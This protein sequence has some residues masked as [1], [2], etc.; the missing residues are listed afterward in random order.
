M[1]H[2]H[3]ERLIEFAALARRPPA[4]SV[5]ASTTVPSP[6]RHGS[7]H[8]DH[9]DDGHELA[10][11]QLALRHV[12]AA[13]S[14]PT[15]APRLEQQLT[16]QSVARAEPYTGDCVCVCACVRGRPS[17]PQA[18]SYGGERVGV[19]VRVWSALSCARGAVHG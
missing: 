2:L 14:E 11:H 12:P 18:E 5:V 13:R 6:D 15:T 8:A 3:D 9:N 7:V 10:R 4:G 19:R 17:P 1:T 16:A